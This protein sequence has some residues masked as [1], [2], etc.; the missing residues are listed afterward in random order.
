MLIGMQAWGIVSHVGVPDQEPDYYFYVLPNSMFCDPLKLPDSIHDI[1]RAPIKWWLNCASFKWFDHNPKVLPLIF[2][3]GVMP[4]VYLLGTTMSKDRM[5]GLIALIAFVYNPLYSDW[6]NN[7]TYDQTWSF[8]LLGSLFMVFRHGNQAGSWLGYAASIAGKSLSVM[9]F[10][11]WLFT[12]LKAN[13]KT[14]AIVSGVTFAGIITAIAFLRGFDPVGIYGA[15]IGFY[16]GHWPEAVFGNISVLWQVLPAFFA[17]ILMDRLFSHYHIKPPINKGVTVIWMFGI[18]LTDPIIH[19]F[20]GQTQYSYRM[21]PFAAMMSI[22]AA[23]V[24]VRLG[25]FVVESK[26]RA[27]PAS[28]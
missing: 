4:L 12:I 26:L 22:F 6:K 21:V 15:D 28:S 25:N 23:M 5:I 18:L 24:I 14:A 27:I 1:N 8:F 10:P 16:P 17:L 20:T 2:N 19:L 7:G 11:L 3:I 13:G 9:Y